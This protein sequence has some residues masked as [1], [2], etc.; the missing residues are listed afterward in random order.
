MYISSSRVRGE[1]VGEEFGLICTYTLIHILRADI[2]IHSV[3]MYT[4]T[5]TYVYI[6][7]ASQR[8]GGLRE[9][10]THVYIPTPTHILYTHIYTYICAYIECA[11]QRGG[12]RRGA[13]S[14]NLLTHTHTLHSYIHTN[15][16]IHVYICMYICVWSARVRGEVVGVRAHMYIH[17]HTH[18]LHSYFQISKQRGG[19]NGSRPHHA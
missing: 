16:H 4:H 12:G 6:G 5:Y 10:R 1:V 11:S 9:V 18:T 17:T 3:H 8:G 14:I 13:Q 15:I 2:H 7:C 19:T